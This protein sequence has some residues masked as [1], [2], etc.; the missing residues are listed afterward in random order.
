[1]IPKLSLIIWSLVS[2]LL[3]IQFSAQAKSPKAINEESKPLIKESQSTPKSGAHSNVGPEIKSQSAADDGSKRFQS[4]MMSGGFKPSDTKPESIGPNEPWNLHGLVPTFVDREQGDEM[5]AL[6]SESDPSGPFRPLAKSNKSAMLMSVDGRFEESNS[7]RQR[8]AEKQRQQQGEEYDDDEDD[9]DLPFPNG[10]NWNN[11]RQILGE[12]D[13]KN[14]GTSSMQQAKPGSRPDPDFA[15]G[16]MNGPSNRTESSAMGFNSE[17]GWMP[18]ETHLSSTDLRDRDVAQMKSQRPRLAGKR[19][20]EKLV[21]L[22]GA[23]DVKGAFSRTDMAI[24]Y[25]RSILKTKQ[26]Q[27]NNS[28]N[29]G[30][31][32]E[33][34]NGSI[35]ITRIKEPAKQVEE[36]YQ[37]G[38]YMKQ[39]T[40]KPTQEAG[41]FSISDAK[42]LSDPPSLGSFLGIGPSAKTP[43]MIATTKV[44]YE[45]SQVISE[46]HPYQLGDSMQQ[47]G[48]YPSDYSDIPEDLTR[49]FDRPQ[50][51]QSVVGPRI[52]PMENGRESADG[53]QQRRPTSDMYEPMDLEHSQSSQAIVQQQFSRAPAYA[54]PESDPAG[55]RAQV[56]QPAELKTITTHSDDGL[57]RPMIQIPESLLADQP[58]ARYNVSRGKFV[59]PGRANATT[60]HRS[61]PDGLTK[62]KPAAN[63]D[64]ISVVGYK[65][66]PDSRPKASS[67]DSDSRPKFAEYQQVP[68]KRQPTL[69]SSKLYKDDPPKA[70]SHPQ[71][72]NRL[73]YA[74]Q[75][76]FDPNFN[77]PKLAQPRP[78]PQIQSQPQDHQQQQLYLP[79]RQRQQDEQQ[80]LRPLLPP[81]PPL[82]QPP[83]QPPKAQAEQLMPPP[84]PP[85]SLHQAPP[86]SLTPPMQPQPSQEQPQQQEEPIQY[87]NIPV[88]PAPPVGKPPKL[89]GYNFYDDSSDAN[90][91]KLEHLVPTNFQLGD[92]LYGSHGGVEKVLSL[93]ELEAIQKQFV[94]AEHPLI[95]VQQNQEFNSQPNASYQSDESQFRQQQGDMLSSGPMSISGLRADGP[96]PELL[97]RLISPERQAEEVLRELA[98]NEE[99]HLSAVQ[100]PPN[101]SRLDGQQVHLP[102]PQQQPSDEPAARYQRESAGD[103]RP[104]EIIAPKK[105]S[106][107]VYLNHPRST[108]M[109]RG[110]MPGDDRIAQSVFEKYSEPFVTAKEFDSNGLSKDGKHL[111]IANIGGFGSGELKDGFNHPDKDGLSVVVIGDAY[112]Y[113]KI[114]LLISSKTGGLKFIPM[115]KDMK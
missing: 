78:Q 95:A 86:Q 14:R 65:K 5:V 105:K 3:I 90:N 43:E 111:D 38:P 6:A 79:E 69:P 96:M 87:Q 108:D 75:K 57:K 88:P 80:S 92:A 45:A 33:V 85:Q 58:M 50:M 22:L 17:K 31:Y 81:L 55:K 10:S 68:W 112:K 35:N 93:E 83:Q 113:K 13:Q 84:P 1:M 70:W 37:R 59:R 32:K 40:N 106:L 101:Q 46:K 11:P 26:H 21:S 72:Q 34:Q 67:S 110:Q 28:T 61:V 39:L 20:S 62:G 98:S 115:V 104:E 76:S 103:A 29:Q 53:P 74:L 94:T 89:V 107:I 71:P 7:Q 100:P 51:M 47:A 36:E 64:K 52:A 44:P 97:Q 60:G 27:R 12:F 4:R 8:A 24:E 25:L 99:G 82:P 16:T 114:V 2:F 30:S 109:P 91:D 9:A 19:P 41:K 18:T 66:T 15:G 48:P 23:R 54:P 73:D 56:Q 102:P 77:A 49:G 63:I 42:P